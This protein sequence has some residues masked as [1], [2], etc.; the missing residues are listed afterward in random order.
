MFSH[1]KNP[2]ERRN[3]KVIRYSFIYYFIFSI[4]FGFWGY[5]CLGDSF[6]S[7]LFFL[8]ASYEE[9]FSEWVY[10]GILGIYGF[11][12]VLFICFFNFSF[13]KLWK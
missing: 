5:K 13:I 4:L 9:S 8:R 1:L 12:I 2:N 10:R 7:D 3:K 11:F 6:T